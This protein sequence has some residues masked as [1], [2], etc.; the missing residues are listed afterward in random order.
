MTSDERFQLLAQYHLSAPDRAAHTM[1]TDASGFSDTPDVC[2]YN[3]GD[4]SFA[5]VTYGKDDLRAFRLTDRKE[6]RDYLGPPP[7]D[8]TRR[9]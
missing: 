8:A 5:I 1:K 6:L 7:E 2:I 4:K 3:V 9:R